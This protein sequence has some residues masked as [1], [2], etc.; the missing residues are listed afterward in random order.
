MKKIYIEPSATV[1][2]LNIESDLCATT[3]VGAH[4]ADNTFEEVS[5]KPIN[6]KIDDQLP[7]WEP[8][9]T[10]KSNDEVW[11]DDNF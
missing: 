1:L 2:N 5:D 3:P 6:E 9:I 8:A 7:D 4:I 10:A 11:D